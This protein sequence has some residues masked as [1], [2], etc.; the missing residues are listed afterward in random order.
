MR[1][2]FYWWLTIRPPNTSS[3]LVFFSCYFLVIQTILHLDFGCVKSRECGNAPRRSKD[4]DLNEP[5]SGS[6]SRFC[7]SAKSNEPCAK[8]LVHLFRPFIW[9]HE[10]VQVQKKL[11]LLSNSVLLADSPSNFPLTT[12]IMERSWQPRPSRWSYGISYATWKIVNCELFPMGA[13]STS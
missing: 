12:S 8:K 13:V 3:H 11:C 6:V 1:L 2:F 5:L 9:G 4:S 10:Q 7:D